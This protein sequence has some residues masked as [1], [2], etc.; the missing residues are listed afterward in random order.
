MQEGVGEGGFGIWEE[1]FEVKEWTGEE[2][3]R[4][5]EMCLVEWKLKL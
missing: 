2:V 3:L 4:S 1:I 5:V